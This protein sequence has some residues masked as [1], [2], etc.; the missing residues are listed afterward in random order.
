MTVF[1]PSKAIVD[2]MVEEGL[3]GDLEVDGRIYGL[4]LDIGGYHKNVV[5]M[6]P[7]LHISRDEMNLALKL[8][9]RVSASCHE[10]T[11]CRG[12]QEP[13]PPGARVCGSKWRAFPGLGKSRLLA[14][15]DDCLRWLSRAPGVVWPRRDGAADCHLL[16]VKR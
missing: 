11:E 15:C 4:V 7:S 2:R 6:A 9:D 14:G 8:L 10:K 5:T 3:R 1:T 12:A 13:Y 16:R